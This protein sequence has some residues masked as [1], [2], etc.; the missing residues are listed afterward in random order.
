MNDFD[1]LTPDERNASFELGDDLKGKSAKP[2][3][4]R[5]FVRSSFNA[6][7]PPS[8]TFKGRPP[9]RTDVYREANGAP[10]LVV[11]RFEWPDPSKKKG[12][13]KKF[14]QHS[15]RGDERAPEWV[16]EGFPDNELLPLFNLPEILANPGKLVI[17][18]AGEKCVDAAHL[19]FGDEAI[20]TTAA[21][22]EGS[23]HRTDVAPLTG[24]RVIIWCDNDAAGERWLRDATE[25][26]NEVGCSILVV[27][28]AELVKIDG[29]LRGVTHNPDGWDA[30]DA[31][32]EWPEP[33]ALR[34]R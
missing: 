2:R 1:P 30:A 25:A 6:P 14:V 28:V 23:F 9:V 33:A 22:G 26:L 3:D 19:I 20:P 10:S 11:E 18:V 12:R 29:G 7:P 21:M 16:A 24:R 13:D 31:V 5:P 17:L 32:L 4:P 34:A 8:T 27:D 15:L